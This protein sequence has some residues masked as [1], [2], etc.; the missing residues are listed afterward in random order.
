VRRSRGAGP[1]GAA[2]RR[3]AT[4]AALVFV[5][6]LAAPASPTAP[7]FAQGTPPGSGFRVTAAQARP[8]E[9]FFD[10]RRAPRLSYRFSAEGPV[11]VKV[12]LIRRET[13][14]VV[15]GWV[16]RGA[17]PGRIHRERWS[18][19]TPGSDAAPD[20]KY[21][22]AIRPKGASRAFGVAK[23]R[24]HDHLFPIPGP[25]RYREGEGEFGAP[26]PGR[27]HEGK[28]VWADCGQKLVAARGGRVQKRGYDDRLYG[29]FLVID[30]RKTKTDYFYVHMREPAS[31]GDGDR[32]RTGQRI[33]E[34]GASGNARSVGC[35]LH[36]E[37]WP[38]GFR[39][40]DPTDPEP[41]LREWDSWS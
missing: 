41:H 37:M 22:F 32:V 3:A 28:D 19:L 24:F 27:V 25:H 38:S 31:V 12:E 34:V 1:G 6:A 8:G 36:L 4:L 2:A 7:A 40:R 16:E 5:A 11:D 29:H 35:M 23:F 18:G 13:G 21:K 15:R 17:L 39:R 9:A 26:R 33:G 14:K 20:G 30:G 10:A